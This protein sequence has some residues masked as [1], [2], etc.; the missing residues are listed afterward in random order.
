MVD[1]CIQTRPPNEFPLPMC[2]GRQGHHD[3]ERAVAVH[4]SC[5]KVD[6]GCRLKG[7]FWEER[8]K[9]RDHRHKSES[10]TETSIT[11]IAKPKP[12]NKDEPPACIPLTYLSETHFIRKNTAALVDIIRKKPRH[13][14]GLIVAQLSSVLKDVAC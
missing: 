1:D 13:T 9:K 5:E 6:K 2:H 8:K 3:Q 11:K 10:K 12:E 7:L 14:F 4:L